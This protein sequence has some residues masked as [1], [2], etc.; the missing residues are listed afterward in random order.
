MAE[1]LLSRRKCA[2]VVMCSDQTKS[3]KHYKARLSCRLTNENAIAEEKCVQHVEFRGL[4]AR[5]R[6]LVDTTSGPCQKKEN[7]ALVDVR[8]A[9]NVGWQERVTNVKLS[10]LERQVLLA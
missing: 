9:A 1:K 6:A 8:S 4:I 10:G 2:L 5:S 3:G 7:T